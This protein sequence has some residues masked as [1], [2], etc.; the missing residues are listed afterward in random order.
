MTKASHHVEPL[1][2]PGAWAST[3]RIPSL[4]RRRVGRVGKGRAAGSLG[5]FFK[6]NM[7][8]K[9]AFIVF[10]LRRSWTDIFWRIGRLNR[11]LRVTQELSQFVIFFNPQESVIERD[12]RWLIRRKAWQLVL[13]TVKIFL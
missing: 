7:C 12:K 4:A 6:V 1:L 3:Y 10:P 2:A 9:L 13:C 8:T 11:R 5:Q